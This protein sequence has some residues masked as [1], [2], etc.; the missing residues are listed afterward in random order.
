MMVNQVNKVREG[1]R[2]S[3]KVVD[4]WVDVGKDVVVG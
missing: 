4:G 3:K 2:G 1:V